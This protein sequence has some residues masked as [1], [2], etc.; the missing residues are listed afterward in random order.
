MPESEKPERGEGHGHG[1][2]GHR[3]QGETSGLPER[4]PEGRDE[5]A[6]VGA[7][8][9][10]AADILKLVGDGIISIDAEGRI[11]VFNRAAT[12]IFGYREGEVLGEP[13]EMLLPERFRERH[14]EDV[15]GFASDG[16]TGARLMGRRREVA[17]RRRSGEEFPLEATLSREI[18]GD[19]PILTVV[20]RDV[21]ER[22]RREAALAERSRELEETE[23]R[24]R[25]TLE[26]GQMGSWEWRVGADSFGADAIAR[27]LWDLPRTGPLSLAALRRDDL[28]RLWEAMRG[29]VRERR[30]FEVEMPVQPLDGPSRWVLMKGA[31]LADAAGGPRAV[32]GV[33]FD[34]T[35]RRNAE[36]Q[37]RL[38]TSEL[39]HRMKNMLTLV[40]SI[41]SMS[42]SGPAVEDYKR[43]LRR[44]I[45]AVAQTHRLLVESGWTGTTV[46]ELVRAELAAYGYPEG[47]AIAAAGPEAALDPGA[48][49]ALGLVLHELATN[50]AKYGALVRPAGR[51]NLRWQVNLSA[52]GPRLE[53]HWTETGGPEVT[54]PVRRGFGSTLIERMLTLRGAT[55]DLDYARGGLACRIEMPVGDV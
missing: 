4:A 36:E 34:V 1:G 45:G 35:E 32:V 26:A 47:E 25:L 19:E 48:G 38:I 23:R 18:V 44:R 55:V 13:V 15:R 24:L 43:A 20:V 5:V 28:A 54:P 39:N 31:V 21:T 33:S 8:A 11:L 6:R 30:E 46:G 41:I 16:P 52:A 51:V 40:N 17:G 50:A 37:R 3:S 53:L 12:Q 27:R 14:G 49:I 22:R 2:R 42:G 10:S 9:P 7:F 29:S